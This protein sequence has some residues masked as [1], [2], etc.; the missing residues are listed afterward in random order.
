M[1]ID[2][3]GLTFSLRP[4]RHLLRR[5][6]RALLRRPSP[7]PH[8]PTPELR[9]CYGPYC[10]VTVGSTSTVNVRITEHLGMLAAPYP[11]RW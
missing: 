8:H 3:C 1:S 2:I 4:A 7:P 11:T 9:E 10:H 5:A 6:K